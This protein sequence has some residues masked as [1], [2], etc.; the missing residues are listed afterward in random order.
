MSN[1]CVK[2]LYYAPLVARSYNLSKCL[3][4]DKFVNVARDTCKGELY[5]PKSNNLN[6]LNNLNISNEIKTFN[7]SLNDLK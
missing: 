6:I 4:L 3:K 2:C 7:N 1:T 5:F